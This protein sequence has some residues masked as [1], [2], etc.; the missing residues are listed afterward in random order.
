MHLHG[1]VLLVAAVVTA[2]ATAT[3]APAAV[4]K[5]KV[6]AKVHDRTLTVAGG[7][8]AQTIALRLAAGDPSTLDVVVD[9]RVAP[10]DSFKRSR[11]DRIVVDGGRGDD[12]LSLG[13]SNG[14]FTDTQ[15]TT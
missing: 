1:K 4:A 10:Q 6:K 8:Q 7:N 12:T 11:F 15:P 14:V 3:V 13:E 9:G 2:A 5:E